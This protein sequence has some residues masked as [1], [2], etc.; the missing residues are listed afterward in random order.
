MS[1]LK[2]IMLN[3]NDSS[4]KYTAEITYLSVMTSDF[5]FSE[6]LVVPNDDQ[7]I[8]YYVAGAI[9]RSL[10]KKLSNKNNC[11]PCQSLLTCGKMNEAEIM[12]YECSSDHEKQAKEEFVALV[13]RGGLLKP[14]DLVYVTCTHAWLLYQKIKENEESFNFLISSSNPR[15]IFTNFFIHL[16]NEN[17]TLTEIINASCVNKHTFSEFIKGITSMFFNLMAKNY[18]SKMNDQIHAEKRR[19]S[20]V[21]VQSSNARKIRK[22]ASN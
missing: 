2:D 22:L 3:N 20:S 15:T 16:L 14:S 21:T 4:D 10:I 19:K 17:N 9:V 11:E 8:I 6:S 5:Y 18:V 7:A 13:S 1:D 12:I